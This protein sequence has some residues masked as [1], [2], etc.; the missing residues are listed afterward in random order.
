MG[1]G[2]GG[3]VLT[4]DEASLRKDPRSSTRD[5]IASA[6]RSISAATL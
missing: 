2:G 1:E 4:C 5:S 6:L 3:H